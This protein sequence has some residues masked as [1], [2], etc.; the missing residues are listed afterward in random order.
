MAKY[1]DLNMEKWKEYKD[2]LTDSLWLINKRDK[3]GAHKFKYHGN[4]VPQIAY[5][6]ISRFTKKG[7]WILDPFLGSGTTL[8]EAQRLRRN[9]IGIELSK[10]VAEAAEERIISERQEDIKSIVIHGDSKKVDVSNVLKKNNIDK[11]QFVIFHPPYWDIIK[12]SDNIDD[13]SNASSI[14]KFKSDFALVIDNALKYLD[15][16]RYCALVIGDKY[17]NSQ[18]TPLGFICMQLFLDR[19]FIL[20]ATIVKNIG[21]TEGKSNQSAIW[22]YRAMSADYYV[23]KHEYLF[24]FKKPN[25]KIKSLEKKKADKKLIMK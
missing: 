9:S 11:V 2:I 23:F 7:D 19:G 16:D 17:S 3:S 21:E 8:I 13:L 12:F 25:V 1:N 24:V 4:F 18:I 22:R 10:E 15:N 6:F 14:E 5:Q 20:K